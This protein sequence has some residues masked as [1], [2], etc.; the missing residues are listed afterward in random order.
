[1]SS[2]FCDSR[3]SGAQ[4]KVHEFG[5]EQRM[6][7][8]SPKGSLV[9]ATADMIP[10]NAG[11]KPNSFVRDQTANSECGRPVRPPALWRP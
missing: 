2:S 8:I 10:G 11:M 9:V 5:T 1:M 7:A 6:Y 4:M 3:L